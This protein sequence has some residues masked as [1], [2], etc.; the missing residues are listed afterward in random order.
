MTNIKHHCNSS[1]VKVNYDQKNKTINNDT[2][3]ISQQSSRTAWRE[4]ISKNKDKSTGKVFI[5]TYCMG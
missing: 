5:F 2:I 3:S 1:I 4:E